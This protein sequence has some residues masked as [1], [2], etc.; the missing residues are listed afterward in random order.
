MRP[1]ELEVEGLRSTLSSSP[2]EPQL[3]RGTYRDPYYTAGFKKKD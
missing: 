1:P 3:K 2:R